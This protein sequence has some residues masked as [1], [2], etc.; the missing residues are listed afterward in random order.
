VVI[1]NRP[2]KLSCPAAELLFVDQTP[3]KAAMVL[4]EKIQVCKHRRLRAGIYQAMMIRIGG[5][6]RLWNES[7][8]L[9][10]LGLVFAQ[11]PARLDTEK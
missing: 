2:V 5:A 1:Y 6:P 9:N 8:S 7:L 11:R 4:P 3:V 10:Q